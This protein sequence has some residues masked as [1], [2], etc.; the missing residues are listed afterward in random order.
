VVPAG[1]AAVGY[2]TT[3]FHAPGHDFPVLK[4]ILDKVHAA[5]NGNI[6]TDRVGSIYYNRGVV[7]GILVTEAFRTAMTKFGN[8]SLSGEEVQWGLEHLNITAE[9][10]HELGADGLLSPIK[11]SCRDH[12]GGG[13]VK[14]QR[15][16][17]KKWE[18]ITDWIKPNWALTRPM[19]EASAEAY[20]KEKGITPRD[21][22]AE[23]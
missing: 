21:C 6:D 5:G 14:V 22:G 2:V 16:N 17:G 11:T 9:R 15:W 12:E 13:L 20:A 23:Q 18:L 1:S 7:Q 8:R 10:I 3:T 19:I 4:D